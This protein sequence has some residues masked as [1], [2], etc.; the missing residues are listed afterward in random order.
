MIQGEIAS[1]A[2][3]IML[4]Y[5]SQ[6]LNADSVTASIRITRKPT[7]T[8]LRVAGASNS[9]RSVHG[10][11]TSQMPSAQPH[12][13]SHCFGGVNVAVAMIGPP[14]KIPQHMSRDITSP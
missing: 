13:S 7:M 10:D 11:S 9:K 12:H 1:Q 3:S 14:C 6:V 8:A 4:I 2:P 5:S